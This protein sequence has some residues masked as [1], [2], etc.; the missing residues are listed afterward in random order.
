MG[1]AQRQLGVRVSTGGYGPR[2]QG[3]ARGVLEGL[4][5]AAFPPPLSVVS[6]GYWAQ[7]QETNQAQA[8]TIQGRGEGQRPL[9][10]W[11]QL[12][13]APT[14]RSLARRRRP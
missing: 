2:L 14:T 12:V 9:T 1:K 3:A 11:P 8:V 4:P 10:E 13:L 6:W 5:G 7:D